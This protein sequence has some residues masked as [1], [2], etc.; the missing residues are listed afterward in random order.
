M[1]SAKGIVVTAVIAYALLYAYHSDMLP[2]LH[3][4][5]K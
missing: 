4:P 1:P 5:K 2:G 3:G